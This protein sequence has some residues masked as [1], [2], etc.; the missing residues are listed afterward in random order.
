MTKSPEFS[1]EYFKRDRQ[2]QSHPLSFLFFFPSVT[3]NLLW[4]QKLEKL[5]IHVSQVK[6]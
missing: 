4:N 3:S 2:K 5:D 1:V 6:C